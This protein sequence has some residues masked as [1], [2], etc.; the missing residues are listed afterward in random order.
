MQEEEG[1]GSTHEELLQLP[2]LLRAQGAVSRAQRPHTQ[3]CTSQRR[4]GA[5]PGER[6]RHRAALP[7]APPPPLC[8]LTS[9]SEGEDDLATVG[10]HRRA[11]RELS[12]ESNS[13][14]RVE[15]SVMCPSPG[16]GQPRERVH[17]ALIGIQIRGWAD[18][19]EVDPA[20]S[21]SQTQPP[22]KNPIFGPCST[23]SDQV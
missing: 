9:W 10:V 1:A 7:S 17:P 21:H 19:P 11:E 12:Q 4:A 16:V 18:G 23:G 3:R 5:G 20:L 22:G 15:V 8:R 2:S 14:G 13:S 6:R